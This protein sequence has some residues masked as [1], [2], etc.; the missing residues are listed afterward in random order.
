MR[1]ST[2]VLIQYEPTVAKTA[3]N[4]AYSATFLATPL[5]GSGIICISPKPPKI[6]W[7]P[8]VSLPRAFGQLP[9]IASAFLLQMRPDL[10]APLGEVGAAQLWACFQ[11]LPASALARPLALPER[12]TP[13]SV[14]DA[15]DQSALSSHRQT[16]S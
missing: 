10:Q 6:P 9:N 1:L 8:L 5:A 16:Q 11:P 15:R 2:S 13:G 4:A 7:L 3:K 14:R 12:H